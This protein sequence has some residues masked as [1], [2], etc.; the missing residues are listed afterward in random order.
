MAV[1]EIC[2]L[3]GAGLVGIL[4][5]AAGYQG[6]LTVQPD[7]ANTMIIALSAV[8]PAV[9]CLIQLILLHF[10]DLDQKIAG[11]REELAKKN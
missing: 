4:M 11:I 8:V 10:Y 3:D 9:F 6:A 5:G 7:S 1:R 2:W